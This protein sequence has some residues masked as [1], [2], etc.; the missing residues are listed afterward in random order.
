MMDDSAFNIKSL[1]KIILRITKQSPVVLAQDFLIKDVSII[2]RWRSGKVTPD[3]HHD[4][5][6]IVRFVLEKSNKT[7]WTAIRNAVESLVRESP[8][9]ENLKRD[10]LA[11]ESFNEFLLAAL[12]TSVLPE[13]ARNPSPDGPSEKE[14]QILLAKEIIIS[15]VFANLSYMDARLHHLQTSDFFDDEFSEKLENIRRSVAPAIERA[16]ASG[17]KKLITL[18][19]ITSL[20]QA[21][22]DLPIRLEFAQPLMKLQMEAGIKHEHTR[23]FYDELAN[24]Q[25]KYESLFDWLARAANDREDAGETISCHNEIIKLSMDII[26]NNS[27]IL[28]IKGLMALSSL[29]TPP[30]VIDDRL[31]SLTCLEP[32]KMTD[33]KEIYENYKSLLSE[34]EELLRRKAHLT[35]KLK[36]LRDKS[37]DRYGDMNKQL[38][39]NPEDPWNIVVAKAISLRQL[40]RVA[41]AAAAFSRYGELFGKSDPTAKAYS[42]TAQRFTVRIKYLG[43]E[44]GVYIYNAK[45][46]GKGAKSGLNAGDIVTRYNGQV[47]SNMFDFINAE[48]DTPPGTH[49]RL[50]YLR[51]Q[52][53]GEFRHETAEA[54]GWPLGIEIMP[55]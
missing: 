44:G 41:E 53:G 11:Q 12:K 15:E 45:G 48:K 13:I 37:L 5:P 27:F 34:Y 10:I 7:Q 50:N 30:S 49:I 31:A 55:I 19:Y 6:M 26:R 14:D 4:L 36:N 22:N 43:V 8:I 38:V 39:I 21:F 25:S 51:L 24:L 3:N 2:S 9:A 28:C 32:R 42:E 33:A 54:D 35:E 29:G 16:A 20:R 17:Y 1:I 23:S 18:Q 40:G 47:V 52:K 46:D